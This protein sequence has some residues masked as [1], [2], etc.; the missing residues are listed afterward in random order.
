[1]TAGSERWIALL[2]AVNVGGNNKV[3]MAELRAL[4]AGLGVTD[5]RTLLQSG[6][7]VFTAPGTAAEWE[8]RLEGEIAARI[9]PRIDV[10]LRTAG[11]W[12]A[13]MAANPFPETAETLPNRLLV[14]ALKAAP[15][16]EAARRLEASVTGPERLRIIGREVFVA[17]TDAMVE[18][19]LTNV[20]IE[21]ALGRR[22]TARNWNTVGKLAAL[23][24]A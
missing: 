12:R 24:E 13:L 17:Y 19:R 4:M 3:P 6:N 9:G 16:E 23:A 21:K 20:V 22:G 7:L 1:V 14:T 11:E 5:A 10:V 18:S 15:G 8:A 2:R